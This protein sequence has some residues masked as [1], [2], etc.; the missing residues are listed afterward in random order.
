M[1][2]CMKGTYCKREAEGG[3]WGMSFNF[4]CVDSFDCEEGPPVM[5]IHLRSV[6]FMAG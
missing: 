5:E 2:P 4:V 6:N 1:Q 3:R